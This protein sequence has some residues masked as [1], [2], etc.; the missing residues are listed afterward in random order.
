[1]LLFLKHIRYAY[2]VALITTRRQ[3]EFTKYILPACL[4]LPSDTKN[5]YFWSSGLLACGYGRCE[6]G[7]HKQ[8][9]PY[10]LQMIELAY[11]DPADCARRDAMEIPDIMFCYQR[12]TNIGVKISKRQHCLA[13]GDSGGKGLCKNDVSI[14]LQNKQ[15]R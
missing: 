5:S 8:P 4:P 11:V 15:T 13:L 14:G 1:M 7:N 9:P 3:V 6:L 10:F 12:A 2:D